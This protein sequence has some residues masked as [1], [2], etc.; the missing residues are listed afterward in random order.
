MPL[1]Y[2]QTGEAA[3]YGAAGATAAQLAQASR[4]VDQVTGRPEGL[5]WT[6]NSGDGLPC[7]MAG[8][9]PRL[10]LTLAQSIAPGSQVT[11]NVVNAGMAQL[12]DVLIADAA[13]LAIAEPLFVVAQTATTLTFDKVVYAHAP[14]AKLDAG[15]VIEEETN[16]SIDGLARLARAP[17]VRPLGAGYRASFGASFSA[18]VLPSGPL[19]V[20]VG[21]GL[22]V[23]GLTLSGYG[24]GLTRSL[25][26]PRRFPPTTVRYLAGY[27]AAGLPEPLKQATANIAVAIMNQP[28][29]GSN[30][31]AFAAG[32]TSI[33]RF[34]SSMVDADTL[35]ALAAF[36]ATA[37]FL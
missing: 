23:G 25:S 17:M 31:K 22:P 1:L 8:A 19:Y 6:P 2:L 27:P 15:L 7:F 20:Q 34:T 18:T 32:G 37:S 14:G 29:L 35:G 3:A 4:I 10:S 30:V 26:G 12:G 9:V 36:G 11:A 13:T 16:P 24:R 21:V 28:D 33:E 5:V